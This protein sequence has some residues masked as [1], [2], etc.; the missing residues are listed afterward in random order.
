[1]ET[2]KCL[3]SMKDKIAGVAQAINARS[4][5]RKE[6][7]AT[8]L[9]EFKA[10]YDFLKTEGLV[11]FV[12]ECGEFYEAVKSA[13]AKVKDEWVLYRGC[14]P[15]GELEA[16]TLATL[17]LYGG[18]DRKAQLGIE[19][20]YIDDNTGYTRRTTLCVH[21]SGGLSIGYSSGHHSG[22]ITPAKL[23]AAIEFVKGLDAVKSADAA[24]EA[25][26]AYDAVPRVPIEYVKRASAVLSEVMA[27]A[28]DS[29]D[30][31]LENLSG[32]P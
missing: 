26:E 1:M 32:N 20:S 16:V 5:R 29:A 23:E 3:T 31:I 27:S 9:D 22:Y 2:A 4:Q 24:Y 8:C 18:T 7:V 28:R 13:G 21:S 10:M 11:Q 15:V 17:K 30:G 6:Y 19:V 14:L 12:R 25:A